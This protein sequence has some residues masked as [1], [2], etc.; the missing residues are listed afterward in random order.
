MKKE[1][2]SRLLMPNSTQIPNV[3][4][5]KILPRIPEAESKC[6]LYICRRTYGFQKQIDRISLTQFISGITNQKGEILD[7]GT[8]LSRPSVVKALKN[9]ANAGL[10]NIIKESAGNSYELN[11]GLLVDKY[12]ENGVITTINRLKKL[13]RTSKDFE[14]IPVKNFNPQN[15]EKLRE[16]KYSNNRGSLR[17]EN[18]N[19]LISEKIRLSNKLRV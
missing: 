17:N 4:L 11:C 2:Q 16:T 18:T 9:L 15:K 6:L 5:D 13:T 1:Q 12:V 19:K 7:Y 10:I 8:G 3:I 14:P